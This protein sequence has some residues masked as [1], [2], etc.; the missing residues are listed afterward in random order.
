M[1][2]ADAVFEIFLQNALTAR[3]GFVGDVDGLVMFSVI[4]EGD[5][6]GI[7]TLDMRKGGTA[8]VYRGK[9]E[10]PDIHI[11]VSNTYL[12]NLLAGEVT[13]EAVR[14]NQ[15]GIVAADTKQ[16]ER[17]ASFLKVETSMLGL[18]ASEARH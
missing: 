1:A 4:G 9:V 13:E 17:L 14:N 16:L 18:R 8:R 10:T 2:R 6:T 11:I 12:D 3:K 5:N 7:W 15:L